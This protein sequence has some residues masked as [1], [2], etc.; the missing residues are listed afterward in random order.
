MPKYGY[1]VFVGNLSR[2]TRSDDIRDPFRKY[3][4]LLDVDLKNGFGF[5]EFEDRRDAED[6][7]KDL[8]GIRVCGERITVEMSKGCRDKYRDFS[9]TGRV[10]YRSFSK[11]VS[12]SRRRHRSRSGGRAG[13]GGGRSPPRRGG[14][15]P[16]RTKHSLVVENLSSRVSWSDLKDLF[17]KCG[18]V[19][20]TDAHYRMGQNRGE[21]CFEREDELKRALKDFDGYELNGREIT[22]KRPDDKDS[23][24]RSKSKSRS[25][26][27]SRSSRRRKRSESGEKRKK[28]ESPKRKR[29]RS[30]SSSVSETMDVDPPNRNR[31]RRSR[32]RSES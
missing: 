29:S 3:G 32:S 30:G 6:A 20:Y 24:S 7:C 11:E 10:R 31:R 16:Y 13:S 2:R 15:R 18:T 9:R 22:V 23:R 8:N 17:R 12:P 28:S 19:T 21:V 14:D 26:S 1:S 4:K 5:V 27:R 25:R